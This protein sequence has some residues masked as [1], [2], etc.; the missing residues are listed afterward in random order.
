M[1]KIL[2]VTALGLA[3]LAVAS[4]PAAAKRGVFLGNAPQT[5]DYVG[6]NAYFTPNTDK[7]G[8][9]SVGSNAHSL[10]AFE[11]SLDFE[12]RAVHYDL[13]TNWYH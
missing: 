1:P 2:A 12:T 6:P 5:Y 11:N 3:I 13:R 10:R 4:V 9:F 8:P 7:P